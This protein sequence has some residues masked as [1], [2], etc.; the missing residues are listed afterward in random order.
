MPLKL[1]EQ[2]LPWF[3]LKLDDANGQSFLQNMFLAG[4]FF[5][6]IVCS[7]PLYR[8]SCIKHLQICMKQHLPLKL[9]WLLYSPAGHAKVV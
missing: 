6:L 8:T 1:L 3:V 4:T 7:M 2:V 9:H 5:N